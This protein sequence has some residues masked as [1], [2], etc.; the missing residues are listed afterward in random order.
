MRTSELNWTNKNINPNKVTALN[1]DVEVKKN[2][3][4]PMIN[5][6]ES[7]ENYATCQPK[8]RSLYKR[9][10]FDYAGAS[11]GFLDLLYYPF[12]RGR[13]FNTIEKDNGQYD[14]EKEI[15]WSSGACLMIKSKIFKKLN[16]FDI[17]F[18]AHME[19]I[20]LCWRLYAMGFE[21]WVDPDSVVYHK[22][23]LTLPMSSH[24]KYYL[25]HTLSLGVSG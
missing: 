24:K 16:G 3:L 19:E 9:E 12:C 5:L 22:N 11:G 23:A 25:N 10:R 7:D 20:D 21:V 15:F 17:N 2:W 14:N 8:I 6:L 4:D 13:I 1:N 18:F